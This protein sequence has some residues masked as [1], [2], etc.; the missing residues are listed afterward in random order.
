MKGS[1]KSPPPR[2]RV[3]V[4]LLPLIM[5]LISDKKTQCVGH[6]LQ[7]LPAN[8]KLL[9]LLIQLQKSGDYTQYRKR[10]GISIQICA[11]E[12]S[13]VQRESTRAYSADHALRRLDAGISRTLA[14]T[15][16]DNLFTAA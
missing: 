14:K 15:P 2:T 1:K 12:I 7:T 16:S 11:D 6:A 10:L 8:Q 9:D 13:R 3:T 4:Q 5:L